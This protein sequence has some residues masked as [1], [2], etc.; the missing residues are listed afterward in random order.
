[1]SDSESQPAVT[2]DSSPAAST[3]PVPGVTG[4]APT[5]ESMATADLYDEQYYA[6]YASGVDIPYGRDDHWLGFFRR[7]AERIQQDLDPTSV[8]DVG[9][10]YGL[11][12][13]ALRDRGIDARGTDISSYAISM[14]EGSA[15]GYCQVV[16]AA[17]P[18]HARFDLIT[19]IEVIE[20][21]S[22]SEGRMAL[23]HM[24][25]ASDRILLSTTPFDHDEV[26]HFNVQPPEYWAQIMADFGFYRDLDYDA[27]YLTNW[28]A[29]FVKADPSKRQLVHGYERSEWR[30]RNE[31]LMLRQEL[32]QFSKADG[33]LSEA[34]SS[35]LLEGVTAR[36]VKAEEALRLARDAA[37]GAEAERG[38]LS[39]KVR[40][41]EHRL[42][43]AQTHQAQWDE[44]ALQV[45]YQSGQQAKERLRAIEES[46]SWKLIWRA[47]GPYRWLRGRR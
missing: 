25:E 31:A 28:A 47:L 33:D 22:A 10:A 8:L 1:M 4:T 30:Y 7:L 16:S 42:A 6:T 32:V 12:V 35:S 46:N 43:A 21:M 38:V 27:S 45:D 23:K 44:L 39:A 9:C 18:I 2:S 11:L 36:A 14:A 5:A 40:D 20:H 37:A 34:Q 41:L 19:S 13:E 26:T 29:L 3:R 24:T 15:K 17:E